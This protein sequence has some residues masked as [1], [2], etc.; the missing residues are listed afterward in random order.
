[1]H[2]FQHNSGLFRLNTI[3]SVKLIPS[4][5]FGPYRKIIKV[6]IML[7]NCAYQFVRIFY[8]SRFKPPQLEM[9]L[10][11]FALPLFDAILVLPLLRK[12]FQNMSG[13]TKKAKMKLKS[14]SEV[15][16]PFDP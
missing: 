8:H 10:S 16:K 14:K 6:A 11:Q 13:F 7:H 12:L 9:T 4:I 5:I 1:M 3:V 15:I 2:D